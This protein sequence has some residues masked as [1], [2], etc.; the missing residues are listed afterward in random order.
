M[1]DCPIEEPELF[2]LAEM[3]EQIGGFFCKCAAE[4]IRQYLVEAEKS[5]I[6]KVTLARNEIVARLAEMKGATVCEVCS[7]RIIPRLRWWNGTGLAGVPRGY[8]PGMI[9]HWGCLDRKQ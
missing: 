1:Q 7:K 5:R 9:G 4:G 6:E 2:E 3:L 8:K